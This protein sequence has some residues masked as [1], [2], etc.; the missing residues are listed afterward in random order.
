MT[1]SANG[2]VEARRAHERVDRAAAAD[3]PPRRSRRA[4]PILQIGPLDSVVSA[5]RA[6]AAYSV[7]GARLPARRA[8]RDIGARPAEDR[9]PAQAGRGAQAAPG[10]SI[11]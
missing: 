7:I 1:R 2:L 5:A 8:A 3:Q 11:A 9:S 10:I 4:R 6:T